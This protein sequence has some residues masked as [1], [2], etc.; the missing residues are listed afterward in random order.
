M[1]GHDQDTP[2]ADAVWGAFCCHQVAPKRLRATRDVLSSL[3]AEVGAS[4]YFGDQASALD[5]PEGRR[6]M[7]M[8]V[9]EVPDGDAGPRGWE[10]D[11]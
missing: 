5:A 1:T 9:E 2:T 11:A 4:S 10:I 3:R 8:A 7:S 6:F